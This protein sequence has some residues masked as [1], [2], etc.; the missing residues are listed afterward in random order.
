[1]AGFLLD[2]QIVVWMVLNPSR[3]SSKAAEIIA[4]G[5]RVYVSAASLWEVETKRKIGKLD[6]QGDLRAVLAR[7]GFEELAITWEHA[8][9][10]ADLPLL[11]RDPFDRILAAQ[12][13]AE[14]LTLVTADRDLARYP[15]QTVF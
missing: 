6:L 8:V 1:M 15:I 3:L 9:R 4:G 2:T 12:A 5:R 13:L 10:L 11:H 14:N 7:H